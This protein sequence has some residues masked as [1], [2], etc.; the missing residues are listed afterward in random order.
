MLEK[1]LT[2]IRKEDLFDPL[3]KVLLAVS[4][5]LDSMVMLYLFQKAGYD[6]S[7]AHCNFQLRGEESDGDEEFVV[8]YC[9]E[10]NI[11]LFVNRF[12][13][14]EYARQ[15]GISIEMAA[16]DL[17][18]SWFR[19]L[20][21]DEKFDCLATAHH[22]DDIMETFFI[23]LGRGTGIRGLSGIKAKSGKLIRPIL[24]ADRLSIRNYA[25]LHH[26]QFREDSSN[27]DTSIQR[28]F[29]RHK[30]L[31]MFDEFHPSFRK[32]IIKTIDNLDQTEMLFQQKIDEIKA[33]AVTEHPWGDTIRIS[34]I[35]TT[36]AART[37]LFELLREKG[38]SAEQVDDIIASLDGESGKKFYTSTHRLVK[39][40]DE[41]I[42]TTVEN[43]HPDLFY[44]EEGC[45]GIENPFRMK[46]E[47]KVRNS[48]FQFSRNPLVADFDFNKLEFPLLLRK[49][50][51]GEYFQPLGMSGY[52]KL[53]D[54]FI[55]EKYS[56]PEKENAWI[57][58]SG[59][60]VVW[61]VG[62]RIDDRFKIEENTKNVLRIS[63]LKEVQ[64][65]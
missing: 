9:D 37:I 17:R 5:G 65:K 35:E 25:A 11:R 55:D 60:K 43:D 27:S 3:Q 30:I 36:D 10:H 54:Y 32:N 45:I 39:D 62:K 15:E 19:K 58:A 53:S 8:N 59:N 1:F 21:D 26:I 28:N 20:M 57:L 61:I 42:V 49:W 13:T 50:Q 29:I 7:V 41:L 2:Y 44:I 48:S 16:R 6:F 56:I 23:N 33:D 51:E 64:I 46:I 40:R 18:Y 24:F 47:Q 34:A 12:D 63:I 52:K 22:Q 14:L 4:G 31:P 38:F